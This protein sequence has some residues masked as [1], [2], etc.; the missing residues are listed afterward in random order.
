MSGNNQGRLALM[1]GLA[2]AA[3]ARKAASATWKV[4][5]GRKPPG[6][7]TDPDNTLGE[8]VLWGV[9]SGAAVGIAQILI[10]RRLAKGERERNRAQKVL[11]G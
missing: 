11:A 10:S 3:V 2:A 8:A 5:A 7:P 1:T 4:G 9:M 6:D